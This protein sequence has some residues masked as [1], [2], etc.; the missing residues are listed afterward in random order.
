VFVTEM[1]ILNSTGQINRELKGAVSNAKAWI[2]SPSIL[3]QFAG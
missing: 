2:S 3:L 1:E